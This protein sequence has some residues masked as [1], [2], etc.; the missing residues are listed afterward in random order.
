MDCNNSCV[1]TE[2]N[3]LPLP[4]HAPLAKLG[5]LIACRWSVNK[6]VAADERFTPK[7][8]A[9]ASIPSN[10]QR[11]VGNAGLLISITQHCQQISGRA[12]VL[13]VPW[14]DRT[15]HAI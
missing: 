14:I 6:H 13:A 2:S 10:K 12:K 7:S 4:A 9:E 15:E 3:L 5:L 1:F 11:S 8:K